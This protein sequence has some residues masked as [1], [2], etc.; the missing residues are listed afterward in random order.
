MFVIVLSR[1]KIEA[2]IVVFIF[3][4]EHVFCFFN[5][6]KCIIYDLCMNER[7]FH[8]QNVTIVHCITMQ[9]AFYHWASVSWS[10]SRFRT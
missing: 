8:Y 9:L 2:V 1:T 6:S 10:A 4:V 5:H 3:Q 7:I